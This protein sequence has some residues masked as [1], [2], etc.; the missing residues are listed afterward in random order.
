MV[1][2]RYGTSPRL[3]IHT[4]LVIHGIRIGHNVS[5]SVTCLAVE[6]LVDNTYLWFIIPKLLNGLVTTDLIPPSPQTQNF[7]TCGPP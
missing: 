3:V 4:A 2:R 7:N 5:N 1:P 6:N